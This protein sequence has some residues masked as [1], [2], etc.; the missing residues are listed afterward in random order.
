MSFKTSSINR[1]GPKTGLN[2]AGCILGPQLVIQFVS[3]NVQYYSQ[4]IIECDNDLLSSY[5]Q[6]DGFLPMT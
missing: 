5:L 2:S 4:L 1:M 6:G 3:F